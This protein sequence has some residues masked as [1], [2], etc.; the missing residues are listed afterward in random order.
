MKHTQKRKLE[1]FGVGGNKVPAY[2][3]R[4]LCL[5]QKKFFFR[6]NGQHSLANQA[7]RVSSDFLASIRGGGDVR[8]IKAHH[9][10]RRII[11]VTR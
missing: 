8:P 1:E 2:K 5:T 4:G 11:S 7:K 9:P 3:N 10:G 6:R